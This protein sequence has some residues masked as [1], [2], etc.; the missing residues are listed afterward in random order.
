MLITN[1]PAIA[2]SSPQNPSESAL[3]LRVNQHIA[4]E[5]IRV[6]N[7]Q[8]V[9]S[10]QGVQLVARMTTPE[11]AAA[12]I[13]RRLAQFVVKDMTGGLLTLQL[14]NPGPTVTSL[15]V[16][17]PETQLLSKLLTQLGIENTVDNQI[18][19]QAAI[20]NGLTITPALIDELKS[21]L[22]VF[23]EWGMEQAQATALIKSYG[24]PATAD[25]INLMLHTPS[26]ITNQLQDLLQQLTQIIANNRLPARLQE[27]AQNS[28]QILSQAIIDASIPGNELATRIHNAI[29][30]LGKSVENELLNTSRNIDG[31]DFTNNLERGLMVL[32]RLRNELVSQ[33]MT[34]LSGIIDQFNDSIRLMHLY[35]ASSSE[36]P[37]ANQWIRM[38]I[39]VNLSV[40]VQQPLQ[41]QKDLSSAIVR[42]ARDPDTDELSANPRYTRLVIRMDI[43]ERDVV[44]VDLSVVDHSAGLLISTSNPQLTSIAQT[45]LPKLCEDL[46]QSGYDTKIS[47]I[48]TKH[49]LTESSGLNDQHHNEIFSG[50]NLEA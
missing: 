20:R 26:E 49:D 23:P 15:T 22:S 38:E 11:Q 18:I 1:P 21:I 10:V 6:E 37:A 14:A 36:A 41:D 40:N 43:N 5:V 34:K 8:V 50:I 39:P 4:G 27:M 12:L 7:E 42:I 9:L 35:H 28:I 31:N 17:K 48:E 30:L 46:L 24:L 13:E 2:S 19:A 45:E 44:E 16:P 29:I 33:G 3:F 32:N 25:S 47:Q